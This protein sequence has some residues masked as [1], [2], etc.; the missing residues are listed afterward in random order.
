MEAGP[1]SR[2]TPQQH[3][4]AIVQTALQQITSE[5]HKGNIMLLDLAPKAATADDAAA[6]GGS[7]TS[8]R[9]WREDA[10]PAQPRA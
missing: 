10:E 5:K 9:C 3:I 1:S 2:I 6:G 4:A 8:G 7:P